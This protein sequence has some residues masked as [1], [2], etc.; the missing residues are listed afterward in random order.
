MCLDCEQSVVPHKEL[1]KKWRKKIWE[2]DDRFLCSL[3]GTCIS[4]REL[5]KISHKASITCESRVSDYELHTTFVGIV[6]KKSYASQL[7]QKHLDH[8]F[9]SAI[10]RFAAADS[11]K[12]FLQFWKEAI[13]KGEIANAYWALVTSPNV[14]RSILFQIFGEV[15]M[16]SHLSGATVRVDMQELSKLRKQVREQKGKLTKLKATSGRQQQSRERMIN[17]LRAELLSAQ[18]YKSQLWE[19]EAKLHALQSNETHKQLSGYER[20]LDK[21]M[22][23]AESSE[24]Q[25][26]EWKQ[27]ALQQGDRHLKLEQK[28]AV[29]TAELGALEDVVKRILEPECG[30]CSHQ[31]HCADNVALRGRCILYVGGR[32]RQSVHFRALVEHQNG[33]FLHH[34]G[35]REDSRSKLGSTLSQADIVICPLDCVSHDAVNKVKRYCKRH[36]KPLV[37]IPHASLSAFA[38]GISEVAA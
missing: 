36:C 24:A 33:R 28:L 27:I 18:K 9:R 10:Q 34:D 21:L 13:N 12:M 16:L 20:Q 32:I 4:L 38:W 6:G 19:T 14:S 7:V 5:R 35:G 29:R 8:K 15:H 3:I 30:R 25:S 11:D 37:L 31:E 17:T 1:P 23:H 26:Q 2:L 22:V